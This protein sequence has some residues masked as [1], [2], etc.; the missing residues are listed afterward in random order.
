MEWDYFSLLQNQEL[1]LFAV[2]FDCRAQLLLDLFYIK[3]LAANT[4]LA[5][6]MDLWSKLE[7]HL[8]QL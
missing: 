4:S 3:I 6:T 8:A 7:P 5:N 1:E 2:L